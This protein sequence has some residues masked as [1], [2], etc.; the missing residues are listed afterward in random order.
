MLPGAIFRLAVINLFFFFAEIGPNSSSPAGVRTPPQ[1]DGEHIPIRRGHVRPRIPPGELTETHRLRNVHLRHPARFLLP[2]EQDRLQR[3]L[4]SVRQT[5]LH[6]L[7]HHL[8]ATPRIERRSPPSPLPI[9]PPIGASQPSHLPGQFQGE[10]RRGTEQLDQPGLQQLPADGMHGRLREFPTVRAVRRRDLRSDRG[11]RQSRHGLREGSER[12][13]E[14]IGIAD[15]QHL[16]QRQSIGGGGAND[17][18]G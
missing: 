4:R 10:R 1:P 11:F 12:G 2:H 14:R 7:R 16:D 17:G 18:R 13:R 5:R 3:R 15:E 6:Q 9:L 8:P